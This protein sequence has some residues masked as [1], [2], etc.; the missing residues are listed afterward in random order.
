MKI[1][2]QKQAI[3]KALKNAAKRAAKTRQANAKFA[4]LSKDM[5][6]VEIAKDV[7]KQLQRKRIRPTMGIWYKIP[8]VVNELVNANKEILKTQF[9]EVMNA[10]PSCDACALGAVFVSA[11]RKFDQRTFHQATVKGEFDSS[12]RYPNQ[13]GMLRYL[14]NFFEHKQLKMIENAFEL[15]NGS[16]A[17]AYFDKQNTAMNAAVRFGNRYASSATKRLQAIMKNII[18]NKGTFVPVVPVSKAISAEA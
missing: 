10:G 6:R 9:H 15:G 16:L 2:Q 14:K 3:Q 7:L 13:G 4:K 11:A 12:N 1:S 17:A 5:Q 18:K 8:R